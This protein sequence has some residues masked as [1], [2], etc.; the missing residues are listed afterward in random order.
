M[1]Y[2]A[3]S[4]G[5][6]YNSAIHDSSIPADAI[7]E[8]KWSMTHAQLMDAQAAGKTITADADGNP[9]AV[10]PISLMT[11]DQVRAAQAIKAS[12]ACGTALTSGFPSLALGTTHTYPSQDD[13]QRN[14]Q[15]AV[16]AAIAAPSNW[17][18]PIW[19]ASN[20]AWSFTAHTAAQV[21][22]VNADWLA[23][24]VAAQQKYAD[25]IARINAATNIAEVQAIDW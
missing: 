4:T 8:S 12:T 2:Y 24:R 1:L 9:I 20:D 17:T 22:Q 23:H 10:D 15:S 6:F 5:G 7:D 16:S 21:Q 25:L 18:T 14:L 11:L 3:N 13:D 19:C